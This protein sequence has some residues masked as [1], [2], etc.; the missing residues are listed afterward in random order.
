MTRDQV[1]RNSNIFNLYYTT[2]K[3]KA[4]ESKNKQPCT[5]FTVESKMYKSEVYT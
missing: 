1:K 5:R 4:T 2:N 3:V